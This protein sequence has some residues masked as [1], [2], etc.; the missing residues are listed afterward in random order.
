MATK[1][2]NLQPVSIAMDY[3]IAAFQEAQ[4]AFSN[5]QIFGCLFHLTRNMKN[6]LTDEQLLGRYNTDADFA[7]Q[8]WMVVSL[9]FVPIDSIDAACDVLNDA[10][11]G[12]VAVLQPIVDWMEDN[13][14]GRLNRNGTRR[15][16]VF[17][18]HMWNVYERTINGQDRTNNHAEAAHL[19]LQSVLQID[20]P[21][22]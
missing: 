17:S 4:T 11:T 16:P 1:W 7:L 15:N 22:L 8:A 9:A 19:R 20:H 2:P 14:I 21:S 12:L 3:E 6:K 5:V 18:V 13:Y 10:Q